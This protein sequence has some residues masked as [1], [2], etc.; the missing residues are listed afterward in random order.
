MKMKT[1]I[2][3]KETETNFFLA[4][5]EIEMERRFS[6]DK[7]GNESCHFRL[8]WNFGFMVVLHGQSSRPNI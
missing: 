3:G 5:M 1:E 2:C 6:T 8:T 7:C 4:D